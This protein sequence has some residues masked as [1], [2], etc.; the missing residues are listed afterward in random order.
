MLRTLTLVLLAPLFVSCGDGFDDQAFP[1]EQRLTQLAFTRMAKHGALEPVLD[2]GQ[3][4]KEWQFRVLEKETVEL[5]SENVPST[6]ILVD[7]SAIVYR[8]SSATTKEEVFG[9]LQTGRIGITNAEVLTV[10][11]DL[12]AGKIEVV[13]RLLSWQ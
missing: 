7:R 1:A 9:Q 3:Q 4:L 6:F 13:L 8:V 10:E 12:V 2:V 5:P 11:R